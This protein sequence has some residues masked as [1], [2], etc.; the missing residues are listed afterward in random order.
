MTSSIAVFGDLNLDTGVNVHGFPVAVGDTM[1]CIDGIR[2]GI[3]GAAAN[4]ACG[5]RALSADVRFGAV[6]GSDP[7]GDLVLGRLAEF[8][9]GTDFIRRDWPV[10]SR[11]VVLI[12]PGGNRLCIND[13]KLANNYRFPEATVDAVIGACPLVF[14]STQNWCRHAARRARELGRRVVV[15]V[16]AVITDDDYHHD[17][18][19]HAYA[20]IFST[21]RLSARVSDFI[22]RLWAGYDVELAVATHGEAGAT[23]GVRTSGQITHEPAFNVR[24]VVDKTGAGD[25]F[26]SGFLSALLRGK[27]PRDALTLGQLTA[28]YKIGEKGST[29][30]F[31]SLAQLEV[32]FAGR[33][34]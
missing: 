30:G 14:T 4:V 18:F 5:L 32:L 25:A 3:G 33:E 31:P 26:T 2:D 34:R 8:D 20:V 22:Q 10:T 28:A 11:T 15:D 9:I 17:F 6:I 12:D 27:G 7:I 21:E 24:P 16:Q 19:R 1:F 13:P 29:H 23:L